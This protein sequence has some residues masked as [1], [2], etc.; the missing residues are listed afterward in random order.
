MPARSPI[1]LQA[2]ALRLLSQREHSRFEL[3]RK[4]AAHAVDDDELN[5]V[6]DFVTA[7][8]FQS[9]A[10]F[11]QSVVH[12]REGQFGRRRIEFE[13]AQHGL[14]PLQVQS[15]LANLG[16]SEKER[17][18]K[19]WQK[20]FSAPA[21]SLEDK[22]KQYRFLAQRGFDGDVISWVLAQAK[23]SPQGA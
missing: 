1:S 9:D 8:R 6:L 13:L 4:L 23:N 3:A 15:A 12:R 22:A 2:R 14:E 16:G 10:R 11:A 21:G 20:R 5:R 7:R 17:A 18:L 19:V